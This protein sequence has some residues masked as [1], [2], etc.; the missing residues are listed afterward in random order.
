M[1]EKIFLGTAPAVA[2]VIHLTVGGTLSGETFQ[3]LVG[4]Q[5]IAEHV[6][7]TGTIADTVAALVSAW[8]SSTDAWATGVTA[9]DSSPDV[10]LTADVPGWDFDVT[11]NTP[12]GSAT[13]SKAVVTAVEGPNDWNTGDNWLDTGAGTTGAKPANG[14]DV[15]V[16]LSRDVNICW[17]LDQSAVTLDSL[18]F[19][20]GKARVGLDHKKYATSA[21][22]TTV[23]SS[24]HEYRN[25]HLQI[26]VNKTNGD[27]Q[28]GGIA[29]E[30]IATLQGVERLN[31]DLLDTAARVDVIRTWPPSESNRAPVRLRA[32]HASTEIYVRPDAE[33]S[34][35]NDRIDEASTV[36]KVYNSGKFYS[37]P[38][39]T[40]DEY[41][42]LDQDSE[43]VIQATGT[44]TSLKAHAGTVVT[45]GDFAVTTLE[46]NGA[47]INANHINSGGNAV[48][49]ANLNAGTTDL[50]QDLRAKAWDTIN[51][52]GA[53]VLNYYPDVHTVSNMPAGPSSG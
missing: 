5:V 6:D 23:S 39:A 27:V 50:L 14:D 12:G 43:S 32:N 31:L 20:H 37:G 36:D 26:K 33:V 16:D 42:Q 13:F 29:A 25:T 35:A 21:D 47:T 8:N 45:E 51:K 9:S 18:R 22:G 52:R 46:N 7:G 15:T 19:L 30:D 41:E 1:A 2:K 48:T 24:R 17:G 44:M 3:I 40:I 34:L 53:A 38:G 49:T 10:V 4:G 11:I 28:I